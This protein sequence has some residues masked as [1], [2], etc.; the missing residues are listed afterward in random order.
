M[1]HQVKRIGMILFL[2]CISFSFFPKNHPLYDEFGKAIQFISPELIL[3]TNVLPNN[4]ICLNPSAMINQINSLLHYFHT[5]KDTDL[6][7]LQPGIFRDMG[8][9]LKDIESTLI[10]MKQTI[11]ED[12]KKGKKLSG[13]CEP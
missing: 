6:R 12:L 9:T 11:T 2:F 3:M 8:V 5:Y 4:D 10:F 13:G 7:A 1:T